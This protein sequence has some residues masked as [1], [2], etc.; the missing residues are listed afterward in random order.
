MHHRD[1]FGGLISIGDK[2]AMKMLATLVKQNET[3]TV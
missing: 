1:D 2:D 3:E